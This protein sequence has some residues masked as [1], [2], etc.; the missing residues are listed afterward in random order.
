[1]A[2]RISV[3]LAA[4]GLGTRIQ[5]AAP[6]QFLPLQG[7]PVAAYSLELFANNPEVFEI[8]LVCDVSYHP[9][10]AAYPKVRFALPGERRQ[11]SVFHGLQAASADADLVCIHD[12][13]RPL[14]SDTDLKAV[15]REANI[16]CAAALAS[17]VRYTL[18]VR[19]AEGF[20][21]STLDRSQIWEMHTPQI[22]TPA[23]LKRGFALAQEKNLTVTDE[24]SLIELTGHPVKL[25]LGSSQNLKITTL[26]DWKL[27]EALLLCQQ[28]ASNG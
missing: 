10:F 7:K 20:V 4:G 17:P 5:S 24:A 22:A 12:A 16:H 1:M 28:R 8:I 25:V 15:I 2:N 14:L 21:K 18:K 9:L 13:A 26:D 19:D 6:K 11:D 3:I 23:L 27:A